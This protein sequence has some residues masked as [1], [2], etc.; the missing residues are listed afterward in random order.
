MDSVVSPTELVEKAA[1][2]GHAAVALSDH[3]VLQGYPD[4]HFAA[5]KHGIKM[6]YG[7]EA[8]LV[9]DGVPVA[10]HPAELN[11]QEA[12]YVVFDVET[13]GLSA[14]YDKIIELAAVK[15][16]DG[17]IIEEFQEFIDPGHALSETTINLTGITDD[18]VRGSKSE[19]EVLEAFK[20]FTKDTILVA[21]NASFDMGFLNAA[22]NH[23]Q[24][25][26]STLPVIDTLELSRTLHPNIKT[27]RLNTLAKRYDVALEQHHR[28]IYDSQTTARL[29]WIFLKE[30]RDKFQMETHRSLNDRVGEGDAY[31][32]ARPT[33]AT[34]LVKNAT[35]L[36]NLFKIVSE[37]LTR[38][39]YRVPRVPKSLLDKYRE[40]L[41]VGSGC[42]QGEVFEA[43]MQ[44]GMDEA[45]SVSKYYDYIELL[46][47]EAY[48]DLIDRE[49]IQ[50]EANLEDILRNLIKLAHNENKYPV[51]V[52]NV[53]YLE[54]RDAI[55]RDILLETS[56]KGARANTRNPQVHF[57]TT[58]EMLE[59]FSF[60][61]RELAEEIVIDNTHKIADSIDSISP[62][63]TDLYTP[64]M[65]GAEAEIRQMS[66]DKARE[67]YGDP[68]PELVQKRLEKELDS[69]IGNGF[70]VIYL[71]SQKL[72]N[73][74]VQDGYLVGSRGSVGSSFVATMTGITEV[75]PLAPHYRC[76]NCQY[77]H[78]FTEGEVGSG[79]DL[80][81]KN[82]P[83]CGTK[84]DSDGHDIPF[85]TFL[86][87]KEIRFPILI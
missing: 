48:I 83:E 36:K 7:L 12:T 18:M 16:V 2:F 28:A 79:F 66:F 52:G 55:F 74:S 23:H 9:D 85:E 76:P 73:K 86:G 51:A 34:I 64:K 65:E 37:S 19:V 68:L 78:F 11:L 61:E 62:V 69:I 77:S 57:R 54:P 24:L 60:L 45:R 59:A 30:A 40:G 10:Y 43:M 75:N 87:F 38:Y 41:L 70:S 20:A 22:Y 26:E 56:K 49:L 32:Q 17:Q 84:M 13:T 39:Y 31:K 82:C 35:G 46:P 50:D 8:Y 4:A 21:H 5:Q 14:I 44:K 25:G 27:H 33:H 63:R 58:D 71:I 42:G 80:P 53:H 15:M 1:E 67:L 6:I 29:L 3:A 72:V 47:K 81:E